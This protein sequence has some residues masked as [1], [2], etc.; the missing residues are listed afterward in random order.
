MTPSH[1]SILPSSSVFFS[2][3][4]QKIILQ[5]RKTNFIKQKLPSTVLGRFIDCYQ[6]DTFSVE[7]SLQNKE[8]EKREKPPDLS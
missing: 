6:S 7:T 3:A 1:K 8:E 2:P 4:S 5:N